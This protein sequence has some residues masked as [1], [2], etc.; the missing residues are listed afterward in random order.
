MFEFLSKNEKKKK[1]FYKRIINE[2]VKNER[3]TCMEHS[4]IWLLI[5]ESRFN[6]A[7]HYIDTVFTRKTI[8]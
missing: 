6:L 2:A 4:M 5:D 8:I 3:M 1:E 7:Q